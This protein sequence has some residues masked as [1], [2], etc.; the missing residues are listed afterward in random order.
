MTHHLPIAFGSKE[1][2]KE[3]VN[4]ISAFEKKKKK[5]VA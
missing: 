4:V 5:K 2:L 3:L 1:A